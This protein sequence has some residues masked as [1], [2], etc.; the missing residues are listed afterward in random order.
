METMN[1][2][3]NFTLSVGLS[4]WDVVVSYTLSQE[5]NGHVIL[6]QYYNKFPLGLHSLITFLLM[7]VII[8]NV[9]R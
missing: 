1:S 7:L 5:D 6:L 3:Y 9:D 2:E 4:L 8:N